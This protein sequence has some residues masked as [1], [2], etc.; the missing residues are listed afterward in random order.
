MGFSSKTSISG[1]SI[2]A[3]FERFGSR[4]GYYDEFYF[5]IGYVPIDEMKFSFELD[6][7]INTNL[8]F[9]NKIDSFDFKISTDYNFFVDKPN[10]STDLLLSNSF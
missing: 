4:G 1:W 3:N 8:K 10:Y 5:S 9:S 6:E 7:A 2:V